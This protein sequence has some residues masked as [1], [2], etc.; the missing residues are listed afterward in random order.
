MCCVLAALI[1]GSVAG[2]AASDPTRLRPALGGLVKSRIAANRKIQAASTT[3][4]RR[5]QKLVNEARLEPDQAGR[6]Q[7]R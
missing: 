6:E 7:P 5:A 2:G 4:A 1:V 3:V